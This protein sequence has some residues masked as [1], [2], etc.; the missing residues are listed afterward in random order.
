MKKIIRAISATTAGISLLLLIGATGGYEHTDM[1]MEGFITYCVVCF[2][3]LIV[4]VLTFN[5]T[6][7]Y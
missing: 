3:V 4:S 5:W 1:T 6:E 2:G 7:N